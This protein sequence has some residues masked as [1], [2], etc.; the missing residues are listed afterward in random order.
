MA[1]GDP[2]P[3]GDAVTIQVTKEFAADFL[4]IWWQP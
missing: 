3:T 1:A 2:Y 4:L